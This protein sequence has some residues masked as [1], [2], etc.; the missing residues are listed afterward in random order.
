MNPPPGAIPV[1]GSQA[2]QI[3]PRCCTMSWGPA[4]RSWPALDVED[5]VLVDQGLVAVVGRR[6]TDQERRDL[7]LVA[8]PYLPQPATC[9]VRAWLAWR[10]AAGLTAGPAFRPVHPQGPAGLARG[11]GDP[12]PP[13]GRPA[14]AG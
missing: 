3:T 7:D 8:V 9:P 13:P 4:A 6:K 2:R 10:E 11:A 1:P 12:G 14:A 5:L